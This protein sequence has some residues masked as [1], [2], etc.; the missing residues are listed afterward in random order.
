MMTPSFLQRKGIA[1]GEEWVGDKAEERMRE[2][3]GHE[4]KGGG[5]VAVFTPF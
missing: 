4:R 3:R 5:D 2:V 1:H